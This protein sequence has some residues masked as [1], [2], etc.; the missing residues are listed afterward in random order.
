MLAKRGGRYIVS[1]QHQKLVYIFF[2]NFPS[3]IPRLFFFLYFY[4]SRCKRKKGI[5]WSLVGWETSSRR[6]RK[7]Y[8]LKLSLIIFKS[9]G[10]TQQSA[11]FALLMIDINEI[12]IMPDWYSSRRDWFMHI[13]HLLSRRELKRKSFLY[14]VLQFRFLQVLKNIYKFF[15]LKQPRGA[16]RK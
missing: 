2:T 8:A 15:K 10:H 11:P 4:L 14:T 9:G 6:R 16:K 12:W 5:R 3:S 7:H 13:Q 1:Q